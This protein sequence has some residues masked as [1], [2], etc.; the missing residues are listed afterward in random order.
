MDK[1]EVYM[2][3]AFDIAELSHCV[4]YKVGAI[5]VKDGRILSTGINGTPE[6]F[7]N[8]DAVFNRNHFDRQDHHQ[9][10]EHFEIHAEINAIIFAARHGIS[11]ENAI[12][13]ST[14]HPC[15]NCL[16]VLCNSGIKK[17][18]YCDEYDLQEKDDRTD[19]LLRLCGVSLE[20]L[21]IKH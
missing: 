2:K 15:H 7:Q 12:M 4:S 3:V 20:R 17:I 9:F 16:K 8:C 5:L 21:Q 18:Y 1:N 19:D 10:N 13:Y 14:L 6:G 11:I